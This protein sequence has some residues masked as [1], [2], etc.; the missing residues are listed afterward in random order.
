MSA[1]DI[2]LLRETFA[3]AMIDWDVPVSVK[4]I[5][6]CA[7]V[8]FKLWGAKFEGEFY[9]NSGTWDDGCDCPHQITNYESVWQWIAMKFHDK[10]TA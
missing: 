3:G 6:G 1:D 4:V 5:E 9:F 7:E 10:L 8:S 2:N